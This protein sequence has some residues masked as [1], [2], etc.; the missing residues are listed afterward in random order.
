MYSLSRLFKE[1]LIALY[2]EYNYE[3]AVSHAQYFD[4][5]ML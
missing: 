4:M 3:N 1:Q 5:T 2:N